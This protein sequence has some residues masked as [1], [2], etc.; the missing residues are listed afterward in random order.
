VFPDVEGRYMFALLA[1]HPVLGPSWLELRGGVDRPELMD[2]ATG[3]TLKWSV[4]EVREF[5]EILAIPILPRAE[6]NAIFVKLVARKRL[7]DA[8]S[9]FGGVHS[10]TPYDWT[11]RAR[12]DVVHRA[13]L[14]DGDY[15]ILQTRHVT[16]FK[17]DRTRPFPRGVAAADALDLLD[18]KW[19]RSRLL[20]DALTP[21]PVAPEDAVDLYRVVYRYASRSDDS[22]TVIPAL[23][24]RGFLAAKGYAHSA[25]PLR[26]DGTHR[27]ALLACLSTVTADWWARRFVD[28]HTTSSVIK[29]IPAPEWDTDQLRRAAVIAARLACEAGD[30]ILREL[31]L[32]DSDVVADEAEQLR[33]RVELELLYAH[34]VGANAADLAW[35]VESFN[36]EGVPGP[37]REALGG[38]ATAGEVE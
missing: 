15:A 4:D 7:G 20:S 37:L 19:H 29:S 13:P 3:L 38:S 16:H 11:D 23:A 9:A 5:S 24:P 17:I 34:A 10:D 22:R 2:P 6:D 36:L 30:P 14:D 27:L 18:D 26:N 28:R 25:V 12:A 1:R 32:F 35:I 21:R 33:L 31:D 8:D